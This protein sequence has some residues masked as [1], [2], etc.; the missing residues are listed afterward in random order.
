MAPI[1]SDRDTNP[2]APRRCVGHYEILR[3]LG[4]GGMGVVFLAQ[5]RD[6]RRKVALKCILPDQ[7][8]DPDNRRRF[9]RESRTASSLDHPH[10][11]TIFEAFEHDAL[12]YIAMAFIEGRGLRD[13]LKDGPLPIEDV[14]RHAEALAS[15]LDAAHSKNVLHR[16]IN[17]NNIMLATDGRALL[18]DFGLAR[19]FVPRDRVSRATTETTALTR[20]RA[21]M[22][23]PGY[24]SPEQWGGRRVDPRSD[25]FSLGAVLFEMCTGRQARLGWAEGEISGALSQSAPSLPGKEIPR[26]L[27]EIVRRLL[28]E[29]PANR[30]QNAAE[31]LA[32]LHALR[33]K[34]DVLVYENEHPW[35][36]TWITWKRAAILMGLV[37]L[38][39]IFMAGGGAWMMNRLFPRP[40]P[41]PR[42]IP[43]QITTAAGWEAHPVLSPD[44]SLVAYESGLE[45]AGDI[46]IAATDG[47]RPQQLTVHPA[48]DRDPTWFPDGRSLAFVSNRTGPDAIWRIPV[49][50]GSPTLILEDADKPALSPDGTRVAFTR[51]D[52]EGANSRVFVA[53][54]D[55]LSTPQQLTFKE[56]GFLGQD[57][58]AW[59]P[60]GL[61]LCYGSFRNLWLVSSTGAEEPR[62]LT[63]DD[64]ADLDPV[65][66]PDGRH[67]YF[68]STRE[69][70][71]ALWR[72]RRDGTNAERV[73]TGAGPESQPA[74][75]RNGRILAYSTDRT[76]T[77]LV[78]RDAQSGAIVRLP[79]TSDEV[80]PSLAPDLSSVV[81]VS[82]RRGG[83]YDLWLLP[84]KDGMPTDA[85]PRQLTDQSG[86]VSHPAFSPDGRWI[87]YYRIFG[88]RRDIWVLPV[89]GRVP[90]RFTDHPAADVHPAWSPDGARLAFVSERSG[91]MEI[92]VGG[93]GK[94]GPVGEPRQ[95]THSSMGTGYAPVWSP[96]GTEIAYACSV[97][98]LEE[99]C[100]V[101]V[102]GSSDPRTVTRGAR[103]DRL[104]WHAGSGLLYVSGTWGEE[105]VSI[106]TVD[107][108]G[109]GLR[110]LEPPV[111]LGR[112]DAAGYFDVSA[113]GNVL[114]YVHEIREGNIWVMQAESGSY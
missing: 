46:W 89:D 5:D 9:L 78:F 52:A 31:L 15:A 74:L 19:H 42:G 99:V 81:F 113:D 57:S 47:A 59:S 108:S 91:I 112:A 16:D 87:A 79:G 18:T 63:R 100:I 60:D 56:H 98:S 24:M 49:L 11:V 22:G 75:S 4:R 1:A 50:G 2:A 77:D 53:E 76:D 38:V 29:D 32:E 58:P 72:I 61:T 13:V 20:P 64:A 88:G 26:G 95:V 7:V 25:L 21:R 84:L 69:G 92:W 97:G 33:Q 93:L 96:D 39:A 102:D 101:P 3:E 28:A 54:L 48:V 106:R 114:V 94:S 23:T 8:T 35:L 67:I 103:A 80:T 85:P 37:T 68:A 34:L 41:L 65:W 51:V 66:S 73:T 43:K 45:G 82:D 109:T 86:S 40:P 44:G 12:P 110:A 55:D 17:P 104:R 83:R 14:L 107:P 62:Q 6:L 105:T 27:E 36:S 71:V 30:P 90:F 111:D 70:S 10:I